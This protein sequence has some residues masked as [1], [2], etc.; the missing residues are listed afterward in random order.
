[1]PFT[2]NCTVVVA[3]LLGLFAGRAFSAEA[4]SA[5]FVGYWYMGTGMGVDCNL[6]V[7]ADHT[8]RVQYS[9]CFHRDP[10]LFASWG[11][12]GNLLQ[13]VGSRTLDAKLGTHLLITRFK[14]NRVLVPE[15]ERDT[16]SRQEY[17]PEHCF[18]KNLLGG[19]GL[20]LPKE[21]EKLR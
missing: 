16:V 20:R 3:G 9:G 12:Q 2:R 6:R 19:K 13:I 10:P 7:K 15:N 8:L 1:M 17:A 21:A 11:L 4:R 14:G 18:W 5:P